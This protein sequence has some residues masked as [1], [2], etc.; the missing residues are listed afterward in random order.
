V[1]IYKDENWGVWPWRELN[2]GLF[3]LVITDHVGN[4]LEV[5]FLEIDGPGVLLA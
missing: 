4:W 1:N 2:L 5:I 3:S